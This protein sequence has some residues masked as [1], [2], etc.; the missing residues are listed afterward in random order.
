MSKGYH[1]RSPE[2]F[3]D[4]LDKIKADKG[5]RNVKNLIIFVDIVLLLVVFYMASSFMNPGG[6]VQ[7]KKSDKVS[8]EGL[9]MYVAKSNQKDKDIARYYLFINNPTGETKKFGTFLNGQIEYISETKEICLQKPFTLEEKQILPYTRESF[10]L[11]VLKISKDVLNPDC[12]NLYKTPAFPRTVYTIFDDTKKNRIDFV[13]KL[14][15]DG[16]KEIEFILPDD[17]W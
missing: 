16:G 12:K 9:E 6:D 17:S 15:G 8:R 5:K 4:Y 1:S 3:R 10:P 13:L 14:K 2:E 11:Q 7:V